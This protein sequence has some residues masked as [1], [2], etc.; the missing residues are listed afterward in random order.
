MNTSGHLEPVVSSTDTMLSTSDFTVRERLRHCLKPRYRMRRIKNKGAILILVWNFLLSSIYHYVSYVAPEV[1]S[2][3][4][5][6]A[7]LVVIGVTVPLAGWLAD[8]RF[9]RYRVISYSIFTMWLS[10]ILLTAGQTALQLTSPEN[11]MFYRKILLILLFPLGI[12]FGGFQANVIQFGVDQLHDS[13]SDEIKAFVMWYS[14]TNFSGILII[15]TSLLFTSG[16]YKLF[17]SLLVSL[18]TTLALSSNLLFKNVLIV[19][20]TTQNPF[21]LIYSVIKYAI[22]NKYPRQRSAFTYC[23][24]ELPSRIDFGK[25]KYGGPFTVEQVE[26]VKTT[27][28][29]LFMIFVGCAVATTC[30]DERSRAHGFNLRTVFINEVKPGIIHYLRG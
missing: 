7:M 5:F 24:D 2:G 22:K 18:S 20:P 12:G 13:S 6:T 30:F 9:G 23:E 10:V 11:D 16:V 4:V 19:E 27:F 21:K 29:I 1:Y 26:D 3:P 28:R 17:A 14:W 8:V 15:S 25:M